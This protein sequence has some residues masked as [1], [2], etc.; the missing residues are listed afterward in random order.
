MDSGINGIL[1]LLALACGLYCL[2]ACYLLKVKREI[3]TSVLL[4]KDMNVK[5]CKDLKGYCEEAVK[6]LLLLGI[7]IT[8]YGGVDVFNTYVGGADVLFLIMLIILL[9]TLILY[10]VMI[11]KINKKYF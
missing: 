11:K 5:N 2:Y 6:P 10:A 1:G 8:L 7:V 9:P 4:S 3:C